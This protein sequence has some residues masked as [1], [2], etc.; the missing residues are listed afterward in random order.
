MHVFSLN[1]FFFLVMAELSQ[2]GNTLKASK[3]D[4]TNVCTSFHNKLRYTV[5]VGFLSDTVSTVS[6]EHFSFFS[7]PFNPASALFC[8]S[9]CVP[10]LL[11]SSRPGRRSDTVAASKCVELFSICAEKRAHGAVMILRRHGGSRLTSPAS[12]LQIFIVSNAHWLKGQGCE[13]DAFYWEQR[14]TADQPED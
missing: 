2:H 7:G 5:P 11:S 1:G 3:N 13:R 6:P 10:F 8:L 12:W 9:L 4:L 14:S